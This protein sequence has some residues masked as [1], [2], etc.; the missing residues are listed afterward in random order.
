[1]QSLSYLTDNVLSSKKN[2]NRIVLSFKGSPRMP[3]GQR[4][5]D[6][7][8]TKFSVIF[9]TVGVKCDKGEIDLGQ[10]FTCGE[11]TQVYGS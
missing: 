6:V 4:L 10:V 5:L 1:M 7:G 11:A 9:T 3:L 8:R 2:S